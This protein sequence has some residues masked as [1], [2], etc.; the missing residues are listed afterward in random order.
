MTTF[1][2]AAVPRITAAPGALARV[3][4]L[5]RER[6]GGSGPVLL[7]I[8]AGLPVSARQAA[9][10]ALGDA[11]LEPVPF[12]AFTPDPAAAQVDAAAALARARGARAVVAVGGGSAL[13]V[14]KAAAA[15]AAGDA[16]AE[17]YALCRRPLPRR[18]LAKLCVPTTA[19]TGSETTQTS[20]LTNAAGEKVWL[21]G[22]ELK[23]DEVVLDPALSAT[24]PPHLTAATGIDALV[25]AVEAC[26]NRNATPANDL[27]CHEAIRLACRHLPRAVRE[28]G[29][30]DARAGMLWAA[31]LAGVGI[32]NAGTALAHN[33]GHALASLRPVHHGRAVGIAMLATLPWNVE[34]DEDGRWARVGE[35]MGG[36]VPEAFG[37]LLRAVGLKASL[38]GEGY[39]HVTPEALAAEMAKPQNEPMRRSNRR[40]VADAD[41]LALARLTLGQA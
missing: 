19:G 22:E 10:R 32:D 13:D 28:P 4:A 23:A 27:F 16:P 38:A 30:L 11:D 25:H 41:L 18:P 33:V 2:L 14:G 5:A 8:D 40:E 37:R 21:W 12:D 36:P 31:A 29:D 34:A 6:V 35:I 7:V 9:I 15:V 1:A 3:G 39:D 26:T 24:L 17:A 20:V